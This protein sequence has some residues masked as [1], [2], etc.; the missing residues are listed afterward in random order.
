MEPDELAVSPAQVAHV[1]RRLGLGFFQ[2]PPV[3][4]LLCQVCRSRWEPPEPFIAA[5]VMCPKGCNADRLSEAEVLLARAPRQHPERFFV[6][7]AQYNAVVATMPWPR[8]WRVRV[9]NS[10]RRTRRMIWFNMRHPLNAS[11]QRNDPYY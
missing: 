1:A 5:S 10:L 2:Y 11:R 8:R 9:R 6:S 4:S 7:N 3:V